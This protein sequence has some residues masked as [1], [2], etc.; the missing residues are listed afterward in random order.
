MSQFRE[1]TS[2]SIS[3][4]NFGLATV[5]YTIVSSTSNPTIDISIQAGTRTFT[6]YVTSLSIN[7]IPG[8]NW[9][10]TQVS[11]ITTTN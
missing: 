7:Y 4:D 8:T 5:N 11:L 10:E 9:Y 3:Y 1:C 2:L 6:G